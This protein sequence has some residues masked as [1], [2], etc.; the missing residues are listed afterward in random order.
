MRR[1][2]FIAGLG[3]AGA[4]PLLARGQTS[5]KIAR[6]GFL[7]VGPPS[8]WT[9]QTNAFRAGLRDAGRVEGKNIIIEFR[10]ADDVN[11]LPALAADLVKANVDVILAPASTEVEP[12]RQVTKTIPIVFAQHADPI[13]VGHVESLA[14]PGGNI[15]GVSMVLTEVSGKSLEIFKDAVPRAGIV[16]VLSNPTTPSHAQ[17]LKAVQQTADQLGIQLLL[18]PVQTVADFKEAFATLEK[19]RAD[20]FLVPSSPLTNSQRGPLASLALTHRMP[21]MF[22]NKENVQAGGLM[23]Y[24]A[25]FDYMYRHAALYVQKILDGGKPADIP[26]EQVSKY[27]LVINLKT[28]KAI[29]AV[30]PPTVLARADEVIE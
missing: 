13:G 15:T 28:A 5:P 8:A 20:G 9:N 27:E 30:I 7:G 16:G 6:V 18:T 29:G 2:T 12:A 23:S 3:S 26:V 10:W 4:W 19:G 25:D 1:R 24:G 11:Q 21:G 17:V 14:R 22:A